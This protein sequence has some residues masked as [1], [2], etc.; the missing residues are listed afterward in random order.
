MKILLEKYEVKNH[1][2]ILLNNWTTLYDNIEDLLK[3]M[4]KKKDCLVSNDYKIVIKCVK[5]NKSDK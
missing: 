5:E 4:E 2:E 1:I 3:D